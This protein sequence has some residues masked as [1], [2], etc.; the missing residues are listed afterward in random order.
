MGMTDVE[1]S[2]ALKHSGAAYLLNT[3]RCG[4]GVQLLNPGRKAKLRESY[5][6]RAC[7]LM[8]NGLVCDI[9]LVGG[10]VYCCALGV[11]IRGAFID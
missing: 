4:G 7:F 5:C 1:G 2:S 9:W 11:P 8:K 10:S 3:K 6:H